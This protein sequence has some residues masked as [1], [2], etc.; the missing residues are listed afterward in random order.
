MTTDPMMTSVQQSLSTLLSAHA[1]FLPKL[2]GETPSL[3]SKSLIRDRPKEHHP[4]FKKQ[5]SLCV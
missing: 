4:H 2:E 1:D 5:I 3:G